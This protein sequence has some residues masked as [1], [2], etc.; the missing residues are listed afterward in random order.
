[1]YMAV[2]R[3]Y[4]E[5]NRSSAEVCQDQ[6]GSI[7]QLPDLASLPDAK[8]LS[9]DTSASYTYSIE[10]NCDCHV[11][12]STVCGNRATWCGRWWHKSDTIVKMK[13]L[14]STLVFIL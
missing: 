4:A 10:G 3:K 14:W 2:H 8:H 13:L 6:L 12:G 1:M 5:V 7:I 9:V 11:C